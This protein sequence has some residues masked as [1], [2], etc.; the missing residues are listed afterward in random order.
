VPKVYED[1]VFVGQRVQNR[2]RTVQFAADSKDSMRERTEEVCTALLFP[3]QLELFG[4]FADGRIE[5]CVWILSQVVALVVV[6]VVVVN[7]LGRAL[8]RILQD[9]RPDKRIDAV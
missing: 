2:K 4:L 5:R 7:G 8:D 1:K 9:L 6:A 3:H